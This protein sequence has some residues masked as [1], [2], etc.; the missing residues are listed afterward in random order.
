MNSPLTTGKLMILR[1]S[2]NIYND[3]VEYEWINEPGLP[4]SIGQ[5][6]SYTSILHADTSLLKYLTELLQVSFLH[7]W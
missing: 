1:E 2:R 4:V 7:G 6:S 5:A 3:H